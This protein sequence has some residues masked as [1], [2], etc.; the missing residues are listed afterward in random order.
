M[1][2]TSCATGNRPRGGSV[3]SVV[4]VIQAR[5][6]STRLPGKS[7]MDFDRRSPGRAH[8]R[9]RQALPAHRRDCPA[10][11]RYADRRGARRGGSAIRGDG[12]CRLGNDQWERYYQAVLAAGRISSAACRPTTPR[13]SQPRSIAS[14]TTIAA[15][16]AGIFSNLTWWGQRLSGRYRRRDVRFLPLAEARKNTP[17]RANGNTC[18]STFSITPPRPRWTQPGAQSALFPAPR[19]RPAG[20]GARREYR[21]PV[22]LHA[23]CTKRSTPESAISH[24]RHHRLVRHRSPAVPP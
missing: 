21:S 13:R 16:A 9:A 17:I 19:V 3:R 10:I 23:P 6:G 14:P 4:L 5:M 24:H 1:L 20:S 15:F 2:L 22:H 7:M 11:S 12:L 18:T 8:S